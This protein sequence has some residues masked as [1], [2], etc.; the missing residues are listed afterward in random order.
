MNNQHLCIDPVYFDI[1]MIN[2]TTV[3]GTREFKGITMNEYI[4]IGELASIFDVTVQLLRHYDAKELLVP[5]IRDPVTGHRK[6]RFD[7]MYKL[8]TIRYLRK[9]G[10]SLDKIEDFIRINDFDQAISAMKS[11]SEELK[12][13]YNELLLTDN[14]IQKKLAFIAAERKHIV[15]NQFTKKTLPPRYYVLI[16]DETALF[17]NELFY[18][19]PTLGFY[20]GDT[21]KFGAYLLDHPDLISFTV[22]QNDIGRSMIPGGVYQSTYHF[23]PY[24]TMPHTIERLLDYCKA[25]RMRTVVTFNII[26]Q[27]I[28][29]DPERYVTE[30]QLRIE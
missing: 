22:A 8:A 21:K 18:F 12:R 14:I 24:Q 26:D 10:Y 1:L 6:Y 28:V 29:T 2:P 25:D 17:T 7:Q 19:Y 27:F 16:G 9:I 11:Q 4:S 20:S 3:V 5:E 15:E 13:R 23:G 30:V